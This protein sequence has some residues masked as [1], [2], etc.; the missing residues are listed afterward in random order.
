MSQYH[1]VHHKFHM[2]LPEIKPG[3]PGLEAADQMSDPWYGHFRF[4]G[5]EVKN[6]L[7]AMSLDKAIQRNAV[8]T[9][10]WRVNW[11]VRIETKG[12][13]KLGGA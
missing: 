9:G 5:M 1:F 4:M 10:F 11:H 12:R 8:A 3:R 6:S 2:D 7:L 13:E